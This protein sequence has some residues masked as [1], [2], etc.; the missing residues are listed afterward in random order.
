MI[1]TDPSKNCPFQQTVV[2]DCYDV[3]IL[4]AGPAGTT[5]AALLA[6]AGRSVLVLERALM[7][8]FH[9]GESLLP[10][11]YSTLQR[12]GLLEK[13]QES[14]FPKKYSVQFVTET[15]KITKPFY[16]DEY[17]PHESS[18]TWQVE[19]AEFDLMLAHKSVENGATIR[20]SVHVMDALFE[21]DRAVG[22]KIKLKDTTSGNEEVREIA[23]QVLVDATGQ[24]AFL[25]NRLGLKQADPL[26][27]KGTIWS[28]FKGA[29]RDEGRDEGATIIMQTE[30]KKSWFWYIPLSDDVV[31]VGCTGSMKYMFPGNGSTSDQIFQRELAKCPEMQRRLENAQQITEYKTTKDFTYRATQ[32]AGPGWVLIGDAFGFIDP[33]YSSGVL[34]AF[35]SGEFAADAI[36]E[37]F[38]NDD[39]SAKQLGHWNEL[40]ALGLSYF[41]RLV[42]GFYAPDFSFASFFRQYP[43]CRNQMIDILMGDVFKPDLESLFKKMG[44]VVPPSDIDVAS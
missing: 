12:L 34:L 18:Q 11:T 42:Y 20:S 40:Y 41:K 14:A 25:A 9:V 38:K 30:G 7:P 44:P 1:T 19:R 35:A 24:S 43:E 2:N 17:I 10:R 39:L 36:V 8:R 26:L 27:Q 37:G 29:I 13:M 22:V 23:C 5:C 21:Q 4:G 3:I 6:E 31:S 15:G 32:T 33:V 16:F 28:Y